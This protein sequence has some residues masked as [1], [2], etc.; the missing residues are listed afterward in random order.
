MTLEKLDAKSSTAIGIDIQRHV[1]EMTSR[2]TDVVFSI[3]TSF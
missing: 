3:W 2:I 1:D